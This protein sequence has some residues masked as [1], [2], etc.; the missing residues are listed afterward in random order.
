MILAPGAF[1][2]IGYLVGASNMLIAYM[3]KRKTARL[4]AEGCAPLETV[5]KAGGEA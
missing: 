5:I 3:E 2:L 1:I 4:E